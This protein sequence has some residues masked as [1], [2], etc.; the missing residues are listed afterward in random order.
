HSFFCDR[1]RWLI[2]G[3]LCG[4]LRDHLNHVVSSLLIVARKTKCGRGERLRVRACAKNNENPNTCQCDVGQSPHEREVC[5]KSTCQASFFLKKFLRANPSSSAWF[6]ARGY[7]SLIVR[8]IVRLELRW[9]REHL[10]A[11]NEITPVTS[12]HGLLLVRVRRDERSPA[13]GQA[14]NQSSIRGDADD[15]GADRTNA[16]LC[17]IFRRSL[18]A[19]PAPRGRGNR[20]LALRRRLISSH[21]LLCL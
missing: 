10:V 5:R 15:S 1:F 16:T 4:F 12:R 18:T 17:R 11:P 14:Q 8:K 21:G 19:A 6:R 2:G 13:G 20:F 7:P 3:F 9:G